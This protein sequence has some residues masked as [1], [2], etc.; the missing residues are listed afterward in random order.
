MG[1]DM[2]L[3]Y[4]ATAADTKPDF[5]AAHHALRQVTDIDAF[6]FED[7]GFEYLF[8]QLD[9]D[10]ELLTMNQDP[11]L[12]GLEVLGCQILDDVEE[13]CAS[14]YT[15]IVEVAAYWL[16]LSGGPPS[17]DDM[18]TWESKAFGHIRALP[19]Q[20]RAAAGF[21]G[22]VTQPL[23]R[24]NGSIGPV[25]DTD[26]VDALT[27]GLGTKSEWNS[28]DF[29]WIASLLERVRS[30]LIGKTPREAYNGFKRIYRHDPLNDPLLCLYLGDEIDDTGD[31]E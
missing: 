9:D 19:G 30:P 15:T 31:G 18:P 26:V 17:G 2:A 11:T 12:K 16:Y 8:D 1:A 3:A 13:A 7:C 22:D 21:I 23:S 4:V 20:V 6:T 14:S 5:A 10:P 27:L 24:R 25:T 29:D 28:D